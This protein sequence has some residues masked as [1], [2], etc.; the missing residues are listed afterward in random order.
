MSAEGL[1]TLRWGTDYLL[2]TMAKAKTSTAKD[3]QYLL[4]TQVWH[5]PRSKPLT[6]AIQC[7][8]KEWEGAGT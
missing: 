7:W 3:P 1:A 4:V 2:R 5:R 6:I 8:R